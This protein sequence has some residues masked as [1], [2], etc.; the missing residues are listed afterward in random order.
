MKKGILYAILAILNL[1]AAAAAVATLPA[2]AP[3][4][5]KGGV[6]ARLGSPWAY[7]SMPA[8]SAFL[9]F[10][11]L[12]LAMKKRGAYAFT[13]AL[14]GAL[15]AVL[16]WSFLAYVCGG[17]EI[18][19]AIAFPY[20]ILVLPFALGMIFLGAI[21]WERRRIF[22][23]VSFALGGLSYCAGI[24]FSCALPAFGYLAYVVLACACIVCAAVSRLKT[25]E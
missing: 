18:G 15:F 16:G 6:V 9:S 17:R 24:V 23:Y 4:Y 14:F 12:L 10:G 19:D 22:A 8:V 13:V 25:S 5:F 2:L 20:A 21:E 11:V 3:V 7:I 1:I